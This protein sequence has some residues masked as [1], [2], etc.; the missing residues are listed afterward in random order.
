MKEINNTIKIS[1]ETQ[2][3]LPL[4]ELTEFQ[5]ELKKRD[6]E[7]VRKMIESIK[8][9]GF[10]IP[11]FVWKNKGKNYI[12]DGHGRKLALQI[13]DTRGYLIPPL[14]V[15]YVGNDIKNEKD[16]RDLLL[17]INS[18]YGKMSKE[19]VLEFI[20]NYDIDVSNFELPCGTITFDDDLPDIDFGDDEKEKPSGKLGILVECETEEEME[21]TFNKLRKAGLKCR[22]VEK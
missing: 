19:S 8:K 3:Y 16:A 18:Q 21:Q 20:G 4:E 2:D 9:Y 11:F 6:D 10:A 17:R 7:D 13:L 14:P 15:I 5:G 1:C 22:M 12:F